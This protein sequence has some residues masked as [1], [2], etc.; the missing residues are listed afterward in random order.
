MTADVRRALRLLADP[1]GARFVADRSTRHLRVWSNIARTR[2]RGDGV[3]PMP[4]EVN[5]EI[6]GRCNLRCGFCPRE[7]TPMEA[8]DASVG[9]VERLLDET[10]ARELRLSGLGE[11]TISTVFPA[12]VR[13]ATTRGAQVSFVTNGT[14]L[15]RLA[16]EGFDFG[17]VRLLTVS[18]DAASDATYRTL[19]RASAFPRILDGLAA[20]SASR[21]PGSPWPYVSLNWIL[22]RSNI[23]E[24]AGLFA[25]LAGRGIRVDAVHCYPLVANDE[26]FAVEV[27]PAGDPILLA[28]LDAARA[29]AAAHGVD[30]RAPYY[31]QHTTGEDR[32][33]AAPSCLLLWETTFV[34]T[35]GS[36]LPCCEYFG[37]PVGDASDFGTAWNSEAQR[38]ARQRALRGELPYGFCKNCHKLRGGEA[39]AKL[40]RAETPTVAR[41][42]AT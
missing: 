23:G 36:V 14:Q 12:L 1:A 5:V 22:M 2:V 15:A 10:G 37:T 6:T 28:A 8:V 9:A 35:D 41:P 26:E 40:R 20:V 39:R 21:R 17:V 42:E 16:E 19:R 33:L 32:A 25:M 11:P 31:A 38:A 27:L 30:L 34:R 18:I 3:A 7:V 24:L 4:V 13:A 29:A